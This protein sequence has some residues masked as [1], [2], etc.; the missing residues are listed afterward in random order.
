MPKIGK[1][2]PMPVTRSCWLYPFTSACTELSHTHFHSTWKVTQSI[3]PHPWNHGKN[4]TWQIPGPPE[5]KTAGSRL[6]SIV[7]LIWYTLLVISIQIKIKRNNQNNQNTWEASTDGRM[8]RRCQLAYS[9]DSTPALISIAPATWCPKP[10][11]NF[12]SQLWARFFD[13][14][15]AAGMVVLAS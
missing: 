6:R 4:N 9:Q 15:A 8:D 13:E 12:W 14:P 1:I 10:L 2:R 3:F 11:H 5:P 7:M